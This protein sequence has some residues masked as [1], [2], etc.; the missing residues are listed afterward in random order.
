MPATLG[1]FTLLKPFEAMKHRNL[2]MRIDLSFSSTS[3]SS[4]SVSLSSFSAR[5]ISLL[6]ARAS[7]FAGLAW[8]IAEP[9]TLCCKDAA[10]MK[11][12][13]MRILLTTPTASLSEQQYVFATSCTIGV[14]RLAS[15]AFSCSFGVTCTTASASWFK[16]PT[17]SSPKTIFGSSTRM[18]PDELI[19]VVSLRHA[20]LVNAS[21]LGRELQS[22][23][24]YCHTSI[25]SSS[26][27]R[28]DLVVASLAL[29]ADS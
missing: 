14:A 11:P 6:F 21:I 27:D 5:S 29:V 17:K 16:A 10:S 26:A 12:P 18:P 1:T 22:E 24:S 28:N 23:W 3:S 25:V 9:S 19:N 20:R 15:S 4:M 13:S 2:C 7:L 8:F